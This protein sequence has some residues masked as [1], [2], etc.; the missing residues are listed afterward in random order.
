MTTIANIILGLML[1]GIGYLA[2][3][4]LLLPACRIW[5]SEFRQRRRKRHERKKR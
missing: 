2:V 4:C 5:L 3:S 1:L